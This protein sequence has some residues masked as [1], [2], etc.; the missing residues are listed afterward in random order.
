MNR[1]FVRTISAVLVAGAALSMAVF[2]DFSKVNTYENGMFTDVKSTDWFAE[3]VGTAYSFG[4]VNGTSDSTYT[5]NGTLT[6]AQ[7]ITLASRL[8]SIINGTGEIPSSAG[9]W[10]TMYVDY[11]KKAGFVGENQFDSYTRDIKRYEIAELLSDVCKDLPEIN[12]IDAVP[13]VSVTEPYE[14]KILRLYK[15]GIL[16]GNDEYGTFAPFTNLKRSEMSAMAVRIADEN[17]RVKQDFSTVPARTFTDSYG[18]INVGYGGGRTGIANSWQNDSRFNFANKTGTPTSK[19]IDSA[20]D[21]NYSIFRDFNAENDGIL[22]LEL[23]SNFGGNDNGSYI[24]FMSP[25]GEK[26]VTLTPKNGKLAI[27]GKTETIT[28]LEI[29][30]EKSVRLQIEMSLDLD[31][32]TVSTVVNNVDC[33]TLDV[34]DLSVSRLEL[35]TTKEGTGTVTLEHCRLFKNYI[36]ADH[37]MGSAEV[38]GQNSAR[39]TGNGFTI[40]QIKSGS[41]YDIFSMKTNTKAGQTSKVTRKFEPVTGKFYF[42]TF[43]LLP[44]KQDGAVLTLKSDGKDV[45]KFETRNGKICV[46]NTELHDYIAN[47]WQLISLDADPF[48]GKA[49]VSING[50]KKATVDID[51]R[52]VD[53]VSVSY[54]PDA[55]SEMWFDDAELYSLVDHYD[56]P[57]YPK[58]A[59]SKDYNVG[60]NVCYLW[61]D[62][63]SAEGWDAVSAFPEF[64]T[65][66]GFYDEGQRETADWEIKWMAEHGIDFMHVC[67]YPPYNNQN[68]PIKKMTRSY[69]ALH[70]GYMNS[71]YSDLVD[72]CIMWENGSNGIDGLENFKEYIWKYWKEYYFSDPRYARL[73]NKAV[74]SVWNRD[75]LLQSFKT[76]EGV[77]EATDFMDSEL[78]KMGYD[79]LVLLFSTLSSNTSSYGTNYYNQITS[80]G[81]T[82]SYGYHWGVSG[83]SADYQINGIK[84]LEKAASGISHSIPTVSV[85]FNEIGRNNLRHDFITPE[86]HLR[87]CESIKDTLS[88]YTTGTWKDNTLFIST[89]NEF[90]EGTYIF[91]TASTGFDYLENIRKTFTDTGDDHSDVDVKPTEAQ[92]KRVSRM[93]TPN[94]SPIRRY[95]LEK[96]AQLSADELEVVTSYNMAKGGTSAWKK[97]HG[98]TEYNDTNG[99]IYG[100]GD[101]TDYG[102]TTTGEFKAFNSAT[103][104]YVHIRMSTTNTANLELFFI[105]DKD[106]TWNNNKKVTVKQETS[107]LDVDYYVNMADCA[108]WKDTITAFR[109]DPMTAPGSFQISLVEFLGYNVSPDDE[110]TVTVNGAKLEFEFAPETISGDIEVTGEARPLGFYSMMRVFYQWDR[111]TGDGVLTLNSYNGKVLVFTVGSDK[112]SVDGKEQNLG[113][114]FTLRD[115]LPVFR[116]QKLCELL[117]YDCSR[118]GNAVTIKACTDEEYRQLVEKFANPYLWSFNIDGDTEEWTMQNIGLASVGGGFLSCTPTSGDPAVL[119]K[120]E[121]KAEEFNTVTV[122]IKYNDT[123]KLE[124]VE[125]PLLFFTTD[126]ATSYSKDMK[127]IGQY[128]FDSMTSDGVVEVSFYLA[129]NTLYKG[130]ITG[131]R[132]DPYNKDTPFEINYIKCENRDRVYTDAEREQMATLAGLDDFTLDKDVSYEFDNPATLSEWRLQWTTAT[133]SGG[134]M[135][136]TTTGGDCAIAHKSS[137][138]CKD[139]K[140]MVVGIRYVKS[141]MGETPQMYFITTKDNAWNKPKHFDGT[142]I[143]PDGV[144]DGDVIE[145]VFDLTTNELF[146]GSLAEFR[147]DPYNNNTP[148]EVDYIRFYK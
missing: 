57:S 110:P 8:H 123:M 6:V 102:I 72:F 84:A 136:C 58:V 51:A 28:S 100:T 53:E 47:C 40:E 121:Y 14:S 25:S 90:S 146:D 49:Y 1:L 17:L 104:P 27:V 68:A 85:G 34:K 67:W 81:G 106:T 4:L 118:K 109:I 117:G 33:G 135:H 62:S 127:I 30:S 73:D 21:K 148:F 24:A 137:I 122:G 37:F 76:P 142:Y 107:G 95:Y 78:K 144:K 56:Y 2:A 70:D 98:L 48:T 112:V 71:K 69:E 92:V 45:L 116:I 5:P 126:T 11:A 46:G 3:S 52:Y 147:F 140:R 77:K 9:E 99:Y 125:A 29:P 103:T 132:F 36:L 74:L 54:S 32:N 124:G 66:L 65:Y 63:D 96:Q 138:N 22:T 19:I 91:P 38:C 119:K 20:T 89:W 23:I 35:G 88:K 115:G 75:T 141:A 13:D 61:R 12:K 7:G 114:T 79:G 108:T 59:E 42:Q 129:A 94:Y 139:Y 39:W 128:N 18:I 93:Y 31:K 86:E 87:V 26:L 83:S 145:A 113:Y 131:L 97:L 44:E 82:A 101:G 120:V 15:A 60:I 80:Y 50:K 10:Y 64:D 16:T 43:I 133:I 111:F 55:D 134:F 105:T 130:T 143:I 41:N